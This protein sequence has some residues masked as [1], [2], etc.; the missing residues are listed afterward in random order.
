[1]GSEQF[2]PNIGCLAL[3][4]NIVKMSPLSFRELVRLTG[5]L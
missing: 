2:K 3:G 5:G 1:M 4:Y